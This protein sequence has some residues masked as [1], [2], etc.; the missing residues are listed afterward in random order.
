MREIISDSMFFD[1][2]LIPGVMMGIIEPG[3][4]SV[5]PHVLWASPVG[6]NEQAVYVF[7]WPQTSMKNSR[8]GM[9]L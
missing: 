3:Y 1:G 6:N 4:L 9:P 2:L 8:T 5:P 7:T